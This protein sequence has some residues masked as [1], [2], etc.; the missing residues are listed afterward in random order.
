MNV[1]AWLDWVSQH[2]ELAGWIVCFVAFA[3]SLIVL[4][5][6]VPGWAFLVGVGVLIGQGHLP[7]LPMTIF[8]FAGAVVG[9]FAGYW[10][11]WHYRTQIRSWSWIK[12]HQAVMSRAEVFFARHGIASVALGRFFGP[13]RAFIPLIAG[14]AGMRPGVFMLVNIG[15]ALVWAPAYLL[16]GVVAG[17]AIDLSQREVMLLGLTGLSIFSL[18]WLLSHAVIR[19]RRQHTKRELWKMIVESTILLCAIAWLLFGPWFPAL[20]A[21]WQLL[22]KVW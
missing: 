15:S 20:R 1:D 9:E 22:Q 3:E 4:G 2:P 10:L 8:A 12:K 18:V 13:V 16:P 14:V 5:L 6:A 17:A 11:G 21:L 7:F 19:Y